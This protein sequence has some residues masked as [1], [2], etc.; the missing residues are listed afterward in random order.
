MY[1]ELI[2]ALRFC[3]G[4]E[5]DGC[6]EYKKEHG[7]NTLLRD[8]ADAIEKLASA[9]EKW[10]NI[11]RNALIKSIPKWIP[12]TE[13]SPFPRTKVLVAYKCGVTIA[14][15]RGYDVE[16]ING[17]YRQRF[18]WH[19]VKGPKDTLRSVTHWLPLPEPPGKER[20]T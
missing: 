7:C 13:R 18:Y 11:E 16:L 8:A 5:C 4:G 6:C 3:D 12:V 1:D 14:E 17:Q 19:G 15:Y 2:A 20:D 10:I 9:Q